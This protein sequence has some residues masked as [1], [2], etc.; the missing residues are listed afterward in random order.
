MIVDSSALAEQV[1][2]DVLVSAFDSAGQRCS[3]LRVLCLQEEVAERILTM[4]K[5][6]MQELVVGNPSYLATDVGPV[7]DA[8]AKSTIENHID[9]MR[10]KGCKV[11]QPLL[12]DAA[13]TQQL[14]NGAFVLPTLIEIESINELTHEVFGPVLHVVR[15]RRPALP[16]LLDEINRTGYGLTLGLHTRIDETIAYVSAHARVVGKVFVLSGP[17]GEENLYAL[18]CRGISMAER[19]GPLI[20][21]QSVAVD[22]LASEAEDYR[23]ERLLIEISISQNTAAAGGNASLMTIT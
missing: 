14:T 2:F 1:V 13:H 18:K 23:L 6:A 22:A 12:A 20:S 21:V 3:A 7:I 19:T 15:Y 5:G 11:F 4:L 10:A 9:K 17:T 16:T 8:S